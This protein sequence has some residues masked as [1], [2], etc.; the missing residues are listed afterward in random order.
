MV[1]RR[2]VPSKPASADNLSHV[3][4]EKGCGTQGLP[5]SAPYSTTIRAP[6]GRSISRTDSRTG[7][8]SRTKCNELAI[9]TPSRPATLIGRVKSATTVSIAVAGNLLRTSS[10]SRFS[11]PESRSI[12]VIFAL[13]PATSANARV[14]APSPAP[15]SAHSPPFLPIPSRIRATRS[16][17]S[18]A[19]GDQLLRLGRYVGGDP[20]HLFFTDDEGVE[21]MLE[22]ERCELVGGERADV[23]DSADG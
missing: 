2:R 10:R 16:A 6:P 9:T 17:C 13:G 19:R 1:R 15:R 22:R 5:R 4:Y 3:G 21:A 18:T 23:D 7:L 8:F 12:A 20:L 14:K 11:E